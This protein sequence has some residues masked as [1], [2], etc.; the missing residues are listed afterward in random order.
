MPEIACPSCGGPVPLRSAALPYAVCPYCST[1][2]ARTGDDVAAIGKSAVLPFDVSPIELGTTLEKDGR[3]F[4]AVGRVR[5]GWSDGSWN[6]WLLRGPDGTNVWLGEAMGWFMWLTETP[7]LEDDPVFRRFAAG[8]PVMVGEEIAEGSHAY[9][10]ADIKQAHCLGGE[11]ELPFPCP[12][13]WTM[14]SLDCR[15]PEGG[16]LS[17]QRDADGVS[18]WRGQYHDLADLAPRKLRKIEG[19]PAP[20]FAA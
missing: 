20:A 14:T 3:R 5:W 7:G 19:W 8:E 1:L 10:V 12:P 4:E 18:A 16:A 9:T 11:G 13:T 6:E 17:L 2:I 15:S